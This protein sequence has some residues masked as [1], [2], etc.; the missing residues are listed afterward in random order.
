MDIDVASKLFPN[1]TTIIVQLL[2]TGVMFFCFKQFLWKHVR[3]YL[4]KRAEYIEGNMQEAKD[5]NEKAKTLLVE[6]EEKARQ[7]ALEYQ[8][9]LATAKEDAQKQQEK[10]LAEAREQA[11]IKMAQADQAIEA[12]KAQARQDMREEMVDIALEVASRLMATQMTSEE[13]KK[14]AEGFIDQVVN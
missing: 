10:I 3:A 11:A 4:G 14:M 6:S 8:Q 9:I 2:S 1:L 12:Q 7:S 13:N 5:M